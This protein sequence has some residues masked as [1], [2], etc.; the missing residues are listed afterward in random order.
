MLYI[1]VDFG[2]TKIEAAALDADG[3]FL[4]RQRKPNPGNYADALKTVGDLIHAVE[5]EAHARAQG[6]GAQGQGA[7]H[8][9]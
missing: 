1:G 3:N 2:G 7:A 4:S 8:N 5:A 6:E 9:G